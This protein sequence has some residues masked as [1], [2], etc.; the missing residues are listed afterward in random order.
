MD[1]LSY[2]YFT[3]LVK[4]M[5]MTRTA[6]R[7]FISQQTLSN[8]I[9]RLERY[10]GVSLF[11]RKPSLT[12]T[13]AGKQLLAYAN[14]VNREMTNAKKRLSEIAGEERGLIRF[15]ASAQRLD[16]CI[17]QVF[18][19][20]SARYPNIS[21]SLTDAISKKLEPMLLN[22]TL[23][24]AIIS[25]IESS[26]RLAVKP[27]M[28]D[29]IYLCVDDGLL[30]HCCPDAEALKRRAIH[31]ANIR[32]FKDLPFSML[33]TRLGAIIDKYM[34]EEKIVPKVCITSSHTRVSS[35]VCF[36]GV[37][38]CFV[39]LVTLVTQQIPDTVDIFPLYHDGQPV[40]QDISLAWLEGRYLTQYDHYF[41]DLISAQCKQLESRNFTRIV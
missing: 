37:A 8:H 41:M 6:N 36:Q 20:M 19:L 24:F 15:G 10:Y 14:G 11:D 34:N 17:P 5:N 39:P 23:D 3:E 18:P 22:E 30:W 12:L 35:I 13:F 28:K 4:D 9:Q 27:L 40:F 33:T 29:Q 31:G 2:Y 21:I 1:T 25:T 38:A 26:F 32:D 16:A 7:L